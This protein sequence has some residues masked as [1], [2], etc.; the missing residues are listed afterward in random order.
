MTEDIEIMNLKVQS[1][2]LF[3][4]GG[5]VSKTPYWDCSYVL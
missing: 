3:P 5:V 1:Y 4:A 2:T